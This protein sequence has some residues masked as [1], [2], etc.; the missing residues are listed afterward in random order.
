M[1]LWHQRTPGGIHC[2][3]FGPEFRAELDTINSA[4]IPPGPVR[5]TC[6]ALR[7]SGGARHVTGQ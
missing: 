6:G 2:V 3:E 7:F 4:A 5:L 1:P